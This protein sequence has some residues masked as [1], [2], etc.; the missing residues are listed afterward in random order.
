MNCKVSYNSKD[1][2]RCM[3]RK[4]SLLLH[5]H[6][7]LGLLYCGLWVLWYPLDRE[8]YHTAVSG[9][10]GWSWLIAAMWLCVCLYW[11]YGTGQWSRWLWVNS[12]GSANSIRCYRPARD[13][14]VWPDLILCSSAT[15]WK[16]KKVAV[17]IFKKKCNSHWVADTLESYK[18]HC[19]AYVHPVIRQEQHGNM[20][21]NRHGTDHGFETTQEGCQFGSFLIDQALPCRL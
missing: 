5:Y 6:L 16:K 11:V 17:S 14:S 10:F 8:Q 3:K 19:S 15:I 21:R 18:V 1:V 20:D 9:G 13:G 2:F 12:R 7:W 4:L